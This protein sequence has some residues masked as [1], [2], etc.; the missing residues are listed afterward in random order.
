[1]GTQLELK[2][3]KSGCAGGDLHKA[4]VNAF[5]EFM[6]MTQDMALLPCLIHG[7]PGLEDE[8]AFMT[9]CLPEKYHMQGDGDHGRKRGCKIPDALLEYQ[10]WDC[11][12]EPIDISCDGSIIRGNGTIAELK[13]QLLLDYI[14]M[15][16]NSEL[17]SELPH[18]KL[19]GINHP[20]NAIWIIEI[21]RFQADKWDDLPVIHIGFDSRITV[22]NNPHLEDGDLILEHIQTHFPE[23]LL[24]L[25][26]SS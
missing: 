24:K 25:K 1:M 12:G 6:Y 8:Q 7:E 4:I 26:K 10:A 15:V 9:T 19:L 22:L 11:E 23:Y 5:F 17:W 3:V 18:S 14:E 20:K 13:G 16:N 21:G 2:F